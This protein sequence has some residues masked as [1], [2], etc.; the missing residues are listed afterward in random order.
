MATSFVLYKLPNQEHIHYIETKAKESYN[1]EFVK[2]LKGPHFVV[3]PF[4]VDSKTPVFAMPAKDIQVFSEH[5]LLEYDFPFEERKAFGVNETPKKEHISKAS[6]LRCKMENESYH[7]IVLSRVKKVK[8]ENKSLQQI[9]LDLSKNQPSAFVYLL[10]LPNGQLWCGATPETL[11]SYEKGQLKTMAMAGTQTLDHQEAKELEW[12][13]KE[14]DEQKWVQ[15]DIEKSFKKSNVSFSKSKPYTTK[16][17]HLAHIRTDYSA[18]CST[19][20]ASQILVDLHPTPAV[21]GTPTEETRK[22]IIHVESHK[23]QYYSGYLGLYAPQ[24]FEL[25]V[26]LR[27]MLIDKVNFHLFVGGGLTKDSDP[28][29]EW[30]ETENK[31]LTLLNTL[32]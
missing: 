31:A 14:L 17:G 5:E 32:I 12:Q 25:F 3:A 7:K 13:E 4:Q 16:A 6:I 29:L 21:C 11:A 15:D 2:D 19:K 30:E 23:R 9:F 28:D 8:R 18:K 20:K 22:E 24:N 27:C 26:N 1:I 10:Q